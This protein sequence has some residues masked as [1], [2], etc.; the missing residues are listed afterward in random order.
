VHPSEIRYLF[1]YD[2]WGTRRVLNVAVHLSEEEWSRPEVVGERGIGGVLVH[3]LG[4]HMRWR[5]GWQG[6]TDRP[7]PELDPLPSP[8]DL[9]D[10]WEIE[11]NALD[12]FLDGLDE[13][14]L[15][16]PYDAFRLWQTMLHLVNH[17]TQHRS[18]AAALLTRAGHSPGDL[19]LIDFANERLGD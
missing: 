7:R 11:W 14:R 9:R 4:A 8:A 12:E 2:R 10:R 16:A 6:R 19:D 13:A 1:D 17:G 15:N 18:E 3:A 5:G